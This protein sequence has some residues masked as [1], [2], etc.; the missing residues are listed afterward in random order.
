MEDDMHFVE[1]CYRLPGKPW[2][3]FIISKRMETAK[4]EHHFSKWKS[5]VTG[6]VFGVPKIMRLNKTV[7]EELLSSALGISGWHE[8]R[9]P[10]SIVIR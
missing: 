3:V 9:G 10:D 6:I 1:G 4:V 5:G 8:V 7:V 2:E